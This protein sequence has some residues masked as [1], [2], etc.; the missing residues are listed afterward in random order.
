MLVLQV[1]QIVVHWAKKEYCIRSV[2]LGHN[3]I[4]DSTT[5][6]FDPDLALISAIRTKLPH[7]KHQLCVWHVEQNIV[8][9]LNNKLKDKFIAF[10]KDFKAV[11]I[12]TSVEQFN[13]WWDCL[14][15]EYTKA[16]TYMKEQIRTT[17]QSEATN[18]HLKCLLNHI[19]PL[20]E[21]INALEK[22]THH[23]LQRYQYQ[24]F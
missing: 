6:M 17:Q 15:T 9:N 21:L 7:I 24:Q 20:F 5:I 13:I 3:H 16:S 8:K 19:A 10:S 2:D 11:I 23:Q 14:L 22:L 4:L 18:A 12:E 1:T